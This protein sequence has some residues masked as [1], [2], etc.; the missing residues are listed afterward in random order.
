MCTFAPLLLS[1]SSSIVDAPQADFFTHAPDTPYD[2]V[3]DCTFLCAIDPS[4]RQDWATQM[5]KLIRPGGE[6]VSLVFPCEDF[7]IPGGGP[8][9]KLSPQIVEELLEPN[10]FESVSLTDVPQEQWARGRQEYLYR[11][12]RK[13]E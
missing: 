6:I 12:R 13:A 11:W 2:L 1:F 3:Y 7:G 4:R 9:F 10:G 5:S 8:P